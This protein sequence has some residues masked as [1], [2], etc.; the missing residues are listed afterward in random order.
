MIVSPSILP[1][2]DISVHESGHYIIGQSLGIPCKPPE[3]S[4]DRQS[5][6][7]ATDVEPLPD[8]TTK[9]EWIGRFPPDLVRK[10]AMARATMSLAGCAAECHLNRSPWAHHRIVC[11][12]DDLDNAQA[13]L[14]DAGC[15][16]ADLWICWQ[17][18]RLAVERQ[19]QA[20]VELARTL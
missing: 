18:A 4:A 2:R 9:A 12:G 6:H 19:W 20:I 15:S 5:G 14:A 7:V 11:G 13:V 17:R 1:T 16:D 8:G 3:I 10:V